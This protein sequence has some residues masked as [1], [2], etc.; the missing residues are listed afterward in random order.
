M[1]ILRFPL[2]WGGG[3]GG[4]AFA[5]QAPSAAPPSRPIR[6]AGRKRSGNPYASLGGDSDSDNSDANEPENSVGSAPAGGDEKQ[7]NL[8]F[9]Q[10]S[11]VFHGFISNVSGGGSGSREV[12]GV[13]ASP[14][15][16]VE[17]QV[18]SEDDDEDP[19]L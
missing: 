12:G 11:G 13:V 6:S 17:A 5:L 15:D 16:V 8:A 18:A 19:D 9:A 14:R 2:C 10:P 1:I 3:W 4:T 7:K